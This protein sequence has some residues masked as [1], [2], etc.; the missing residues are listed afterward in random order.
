MHFF[1]SEFIQTTL[2]NIHLPI[3]SWYSAINEKFHNTKRYNP[4]V[5][6]KPGTWTTPEADDARRLIFHQNDKTKQKSA[7]DLITI[8]PDGSVCLGM[9]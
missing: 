2:S 1:G 6:S 3:F 8:L 7:W 9:Y 4:L 5:W